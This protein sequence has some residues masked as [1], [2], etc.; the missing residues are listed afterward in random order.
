MRSDLNQLYAFIQKA[1]RSTY[2]TSGV[3]STSYDESGCKV[4]K[5]SEGDYHYTDT[6]TGFFKSRGQEVVRHNDTPIWIASYGGGMTVEDKELAL[7]TFGFL[8][9]A[10]LTDDAAMQSFRGPRSLKDGD[11]TYTYQQE[12]DITEFSGYEEIHHKGKLVF[13]H[14][15]IGGLVINHS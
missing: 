6:Y 11:W 13:F 3:D 10:F 12:G 4:L 5:Y 8:K 14:R 15:I 1:G 7:A 9:K 2:A